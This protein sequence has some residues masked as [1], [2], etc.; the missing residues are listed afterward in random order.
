MVIFLSN[1]AKDGIDIARNYVNNIVDK[2]IDKFNKKCLAGEGSGTTLTNNEIKDTMKAIKF[3]E[4]VEILL[5]AAVRTITGQEE[6]F[7]IFFRPL[8]H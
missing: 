2:K 8:M 1:A 3:L 4:S 6:G 5:K 7:F